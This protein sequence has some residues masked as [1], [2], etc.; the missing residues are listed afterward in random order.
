M[1]GMRRDIP[2]VRILPMSDQADGFRGRSIQDVQ[3]RCFLRELPAVNGRYRYP[4]SGLNAEPGTI[5]LFQFK[6]RIIATG[7]FLHDEKF[8]WPKRGYAGAMHFDSVVAR[9]VRSGMRFATGEAER[10]SSP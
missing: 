10:S 1:A 7:V 9:Y 6:A 3:D 4:S 2:A 5:V 8:E